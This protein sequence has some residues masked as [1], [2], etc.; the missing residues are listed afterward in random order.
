MSVLDD[1]RAATTPEEAWRIAAAVKVSM[2]ATVSHACPL[3]ADVHL[4]PT[5]ASHAV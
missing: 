5:E 2:P 3:C 4:Q 1:L